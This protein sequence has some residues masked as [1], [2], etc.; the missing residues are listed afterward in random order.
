[1]GSPLPPPGVRTW[2][3]FGASGSKM[4]GIPMAMSQIFSFISPRPRGDMAEFSFIVTADAG[5]GAVPVEEAG[6]ATHNDPPANGAD[7]V[8][9]AL[10]RDGPLSPGSTDEFLI[11]NGDI[12]YARGWPWIWERYFDLMQGLATAVPWMTT[13]GNHEVDTAANPVKLASGHDSGGECGVATLKRFP[14]YTSTSEMWYSFSYGS[15]HCVMLSSEHPVSE[16]VRFFEDDLG[17]VNRTETPWVLV[18]LHRPLFGS[19]KRD[20]I[21]MKLAFTWHK[22]FVSHAIDFV[23]TGHEHFYERLCV[24]A[25]ETSCVLDGSRDRPVYI[26]DGSAGAEFSPKHSTPPS[27]ISVHKEFSKWGYGRMSVTKG[28]LTFTHYHTDNTISDSVSLPRVIEWG[29]VSIQLTTESH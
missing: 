10:Y 1:M 26:I 27:N 11:L 4:D 2:Y 8:A 7:S 29:P 6:G 18:F 22:L 12:S 24:V 25:N 19:E 14:H 21:D 3:S 9:A 17:R 20:T 28:A 5:I 23:M 15:V 13:V 16:Q